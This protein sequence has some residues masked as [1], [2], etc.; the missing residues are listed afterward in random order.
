[1]RPKPPTSLINSMSF[2]IIGI[3]IISLSAMF[4]NYQKFETLKTSELS[5]LTKERIKLEVQRLN[6]LSLDI[7]GVVLNIPL[8]LVDEVPQNIWGM[9]IYNQ[10]GPQKIVINKTQLKES[11][12]YIIEFVLAHEWAHAVERIQNT[13]T[14]KST[15]GKQWLAICNQLSI[16]RCRQYVHTEKVAREKLHSLFGF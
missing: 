10:E 3:M 6:K 2:I 14:K 16:G 13:T 8:E 7:Y 12:N 11:P 4:Y 1:M 5:D 15:H 9:M